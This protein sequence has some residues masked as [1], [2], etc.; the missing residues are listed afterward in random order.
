MTAPLPRSYYGEHSAVLRL[1]VAGRGPSASWIPA[2]AS[3]PPLPCGPRSALSA[4]RE[5]RVT[6]VTAPPQP[7]CG[8]L[9]KAPGQRRIARSSAAR[10][11]LAPA[12]R[13]ARHARRCV[14][15][16]S[17]CDHPVP[18][19]WE[20]RSHVAGRAQRLADGPVT[21]ER[22]QHDCQHPLSAHRLF[23]VALCATRT[24]SNRRNR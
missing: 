14:E 18:A 6:R 17:L 11:R 24:A 10:P 12:R 7:R 19:A 23:A 16:K 8:G 20:R 21:A 15:G 1:P 3:C 22:G 13:G 4:L 2:S 9:L 5:R